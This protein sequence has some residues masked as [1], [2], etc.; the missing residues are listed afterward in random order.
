MAIAQLITNR[1]LLA[2]GA[3]SSR[4]RGRLV[5][6]IAIAPAKTLP[7]HRSFPDF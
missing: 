5:I 7:G 6:I 2:G 1:P 3:P 4:G